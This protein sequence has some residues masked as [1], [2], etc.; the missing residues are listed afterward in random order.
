MIKYGEIADEAEKTL[1]KLFDDKSGDIFLKVVSNEG[2]AP[3]AV[4]F[5]DDEP[6]CLIF[7]SEQ[8]VKMREM[9]AKA[10]R[11]Q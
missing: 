8:K 9:Y 2:Q 10:T 4:V 3:H 1:N 6:I 11:L 7:T 5:I